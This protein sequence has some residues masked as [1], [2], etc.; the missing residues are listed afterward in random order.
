M[1]PII[2]SLF[3][4]C[5]AVFNVDAQEN[6]KGIIPMVTT[7]AEVEKI[8]GKPDKNGKYELDEGRVYIRYYEKQCER[9]I[10]CF[11]L[12]ALGTVQYISVELYYDLYL[13]DLNLEPQK[14]KETR[15]EHLPDVYSYSNLKKG[16]VYEVQNGKVTHIYYYESEDT[17]NDIK[18][19]FLKK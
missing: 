12:A 8:L 13:K 1:C 15:S 2:I 17:C 16:I 4:I 9:K 19:K 6:F 7:K 11:C 3:V 10:E 5:L 18:Q 14:F